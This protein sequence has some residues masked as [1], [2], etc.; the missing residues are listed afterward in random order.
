MDPAYGAAYPR[1]YREHWWWRTRE[2]ILLATIARLVK[3]MGVP[4]PR[5]LDV[6]CGAGLFFDALEAFGHVEG[7]ESDFHAVE[8]SGRWRDRIT[9]GEL[10]PDGDPFD[11]VLLLDVLEHIEQPRALLSTVARRLSPRG[12]VLIT[13]PAYQWLWS[14]HDVLNHHVRRYSATSLRREIE[15]AGL[16]QVSSRYLFQSLVVPKLVTRALESLSHPPPRVP[17]IPPPA[18]NA[19]VQAWFRAEDAVF[20]WLPF[21]GSVMA[22][23]RGVSRASE[24]RSERGPRRAPRT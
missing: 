9:V 16:E 24:N 23:G 18:L 5:I 1:L 17:T 4:V 21:G 22:V 14:S 11:L 12:R 7:I 20:G 15:A 13:V 2:R 3:D 6:G 19:A 8:Q 10:S